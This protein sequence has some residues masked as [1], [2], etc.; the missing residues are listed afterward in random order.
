MKYEYHPLL[1]PQIQSRNM[2]QLLVFTHGSLR[3]VPR[4]CELWHLLLWSLYFKKQSKKESVRIQ[5]ATSELWVASD[6]E[7]CKSGPGGGL[8]STV[9]SQGAVCSPGHCR[10]RCDGALPGRPHTS[11][12][13]RECGAAVAL[14]HRQPFYLALGDKMRSS[15][16]NGSWAKT[17]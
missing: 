6:A 11:W 12:W 17:D 9:N 14:Q 8:H 13:H 3:K 16:G 10:Q 5:R 7:Q 1:L 15:A 4:H 2:Y